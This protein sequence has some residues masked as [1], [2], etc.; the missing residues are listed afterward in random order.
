ML[1]PPPQQAAIACRAA[2]HLSPCCC[3]TSRK[4][5]LFQESDCMAD[6]ARCLPGSNGGLFSNPL[7]QGKYRGHSVQASKLQAQKGVC[8]YR[9]SCS[10]PLRVTAFSSPLLSG[11][12][13][14]PW[15]CLPFSHWTLPCPH[16]PSA[17]LE[18]C[19]QLLFCRTTC[20]NFLK[21]TIIEQNDFPDEENIF[22]RVPDASDF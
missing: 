15:T 5:Q 2:F 8:A 10:S 11:R 3:T 18:Y 13:R 6:A 9:P 16:T 17:S 20:L 4:Y 22:K 19:L 12:G 21:T 14:R 1:S 7:G